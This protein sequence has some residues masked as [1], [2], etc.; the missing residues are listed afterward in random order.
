MDAV[1]AFHG[2]LLFGSAGQVIDHMNAF[3]HEHAVFIDDFARR[4]RNQLA[5]ACVNLARFQRAPEGS[6]QS[7]G[8]GR[9]DVVQSRGIGR[10]VIRT[11]AVVR[12]D[13]PV[14]SES[15]RLFLGWKVGKTEGTSNSLY[16][17][18]RYVCRFGHCVAPFRLSE[19]GFLQ[20]TSRPAEPSS[21][22]ETGLIWRVLFHLR[23]R[24]DTLLGFWVPYPENKQNR[25]LSR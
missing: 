6:G 15:Y 18:F 11:D 25:R 22:S 5:F 13:G 8:G 14:D 7:A 23:F 17:N 16:A 4:F 24:I 20:S 1:D 3:D 2:R 12:G 21:D 9:H 10:K 19:G